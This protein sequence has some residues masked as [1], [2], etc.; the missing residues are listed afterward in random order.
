MYFKEIEATC[1]NAD[2]TP[3]VQFGLSD[4]VMLKFFNINPVKGEWIA[5]SKTKAGVTLPKHYHT[6]KVIAYTISGRWKYEEHDFIAGPGSLVYEVAASTHRPI[7]ME[8]VIA[9]NIAEGESIFYNEDDTV[10][11]VMN[12]KMAMDSYL[13]ACEAQGFTPKDLTSFSKLAWAG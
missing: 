5:L 7:I 1:L 12:W 2:D 4:D 11:G 6:G 8:E 13:E 10:A 3:W 9:L